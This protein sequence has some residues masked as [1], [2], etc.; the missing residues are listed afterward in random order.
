MC[1]ERS[2]IPFEEPKLEVNKDNN[3]ETNFLGAS[4]N[5]EDEKQNRETKE[6]VEDSLIKLCLV[7]F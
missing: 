5:K 6:E 3:R 7:R 4:V 1:W 2:V